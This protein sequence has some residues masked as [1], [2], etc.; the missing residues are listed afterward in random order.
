MPSVP[1]KGAAVLGFDTDEAYTA[2]VKAYDDAAVLVGAH[3]YGN[4]GPRVF[5][6][7]N[8]EAPLDVGKKTKALV[9]A[10]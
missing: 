8:S 1:G 7:L 9:A 4:A 10:L 6:Q 2:T 5:V 3:R